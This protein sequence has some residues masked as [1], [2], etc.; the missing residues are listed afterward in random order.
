[1]NKKTRELYRRERARYPRVSAVHA[2]AIARAKVKPNPL[3]WKDRRRADGIEAETERD[4]FRVVFTCEPDHEEG[5]TDFYG[6]F[7]S[8]WSADAIPNGNPKRRERGEYDYFLPQ[9][10]RAERR[11]VLQAVG[12]SRG[13][14]EEEAREGVREDW[15]RAKTLGTDWT[16]YVVRVRVFRA[17]IEL[18]RAST[19]GVELSDPEWTRGADTYTAMY[20]D[21]TDVALTLL[22]EALDEAKE[23]LAELRETA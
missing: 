4:A 23:K 6:T 19:Y 8:K 1:M 20:L 17:G 9:Y 7:T 2:L 3:A 12:V 11:E 22:D 18:G 5:S 14:A 16:F 15:K 21:A 13:V 10:T